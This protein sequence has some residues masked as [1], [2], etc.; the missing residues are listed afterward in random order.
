MKVWGRYCVCLWDREGGLVPQMQD[1]SDKML[2][3]SYRF[4]VL[5]FSL[6]QQ[7]RTE[8]DRVDNGHDGSISGR[9]GRSKPG[10]IVFNESH[11]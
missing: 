1:G 10:I 9:R 8:W 2:T 6:R 3:C 7:G 11:R 5:L 4:H